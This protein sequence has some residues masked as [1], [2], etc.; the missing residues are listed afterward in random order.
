MSPTFEG[1]Y[2]ITGRPSIPPE[3]LLRALFL[4]IL[5]S[6]RSERQLIE[7]LD[8]NILFRWF[9]GLSMDDPI[10]HATSFTKNR[11]RLLKGDI[12]Q[13]FFERVRAIA[14]MNELM[15]SD[16]FTV[17]GTLLEAWASHKS[18]QAKDP[19]DDDSR[20]SGKNR[21]VNFRGKKRSNATHES[22]SD[23]EARLFC[24]GAGKAAQLC[25]MQH[26]LT[27]NRNGLIVE[28]RT[29]QASGTAERAAA[30]EMI[31]AVKQSRRITLG[32]D[33]GYDTADFIADLRRL[34]VTPHI[35]ANTN[36]C[37]GSAIDGRTM[38]HNGY[39]ISQR[40]RKRVEEVFGWEKTIGGLRKLHHRGLR[41]VT[42][43]ATFGAAAYNLVRIAKL[44]ME[45][46]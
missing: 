1:L 35:A 39:E 13:A 27:E 42:Q 24:K 14:E 33:K 44:T 21:D 31:G 11:D 7:Q 26:V 5:F 4:Q 8:Y 23:P 34:K 38:R 29:T 22:T 17:D 40:K 32:A 3:R 9:V 25:Y 18:F 46:A 30:L 28:V 37:G 10:W 19:S 16:H 36:R 2:S 41:L 12:A 6:I 15:S 43:I 20:P 45:A